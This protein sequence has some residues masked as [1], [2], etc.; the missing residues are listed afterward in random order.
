MSAADNAAVHEMATSLPSF[1]ILPPEIRIMVYK[2]LLDSADAFGAL[3]CLFFGRTKH[4]A[5]E[6]FTLFTTLPQAEK[7]V[8]PLSLPE[9]RLCVDSRRC[10]RGW[11]A[12]IIKD[13]TNSPIPLEYSSDLSPR[14]YDIHEVHPYLLRSAK[15]LAWYGHVLLK[16]FDILTLSVDLAGPFTLSVAI[17]FDGQRG[18][19]VC[20]F[21]TPGRS[22]KARDKAKYIE[23]KDLNERA[24]AKL[25]AKTLRRLA[26]F[27]SVE[28]K[29]VED[30]AADLSRVRWH[31]YPYLRP[32]A[33]KHKDSSAPQTWH[34]T[35]AGTSAREEEE[36]KKAEED[37]KGP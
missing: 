3:N 13:S 18:V 5:N 33:R 32:H 9:L 21:P 28:T 11:E 31:P 23:L 22:R 16:C 19:E 37:M 12:A 25:K 34:I 1:M 2:A 27:R 17:C 24:M 36:F 20:L 30:I 8:L 29:L 26:T 4:P 35:T 15:L 10:H 7:E 6:I 14:Y